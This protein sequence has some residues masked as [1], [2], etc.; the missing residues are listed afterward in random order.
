[1]STLCS[2][3]ISSSCGGG[4]V[5][6]READGEGTE[7][8]FDGDVVALLCPPLYN[9]LSFPSLNDIRRRPLRSIE[10]LLPLLL[11]DGGGVATLMLAE[12]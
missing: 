8:A 7:L 1:M 9:F 5:V 10:S 6:G 12:C 3:A 11:S 2:I 4:A